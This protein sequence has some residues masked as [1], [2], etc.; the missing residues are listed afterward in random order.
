MACNGALGRKGK[1]Y[2]KASETDTTAAAWDTP[3]EVKAAL[4]LSDWKEVCAVDV[5]YDGNKEKIDTSDRCSG[6]YKAYVPGQA[7]GTITFKAFKRKPITTGDWLDILRSAYSADSTITAL[8][9]DDARSTTGADGM[10]ANVNVFNMSESQPL[11]GP[12]EVN[13]DLAVSGCVTYSPP[14]RPVTRPA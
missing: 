13:F 11:N 6:D 8:M 14:A 2:V 3:T 12:I 1:L 4:D 9:L 7:E 5:E 10:I